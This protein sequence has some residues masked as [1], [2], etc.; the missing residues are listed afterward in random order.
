MNARERLAHRHFNDFMI[1]LTKGSIAPFTVKRLEAYAGDVDIDVSTLRPY[2]EDDNDFIRKVAVKI[3]GCFGDLSEL[4]KVIQREEDRMVILEA[5][6]QFA[7]RADDNVEDMLFLLDS[8]DVIVK[9]SV[10]NMFRRAGRA[11][12]LMTLLFDVDEALSQ[13]VKKWMEEQ[14][15]KEGK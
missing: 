2:L 13:R 12:C 14:D 5:C 3:W 8:E 7:K 11:D 9:Q 15:A 1:K 10:I 4:V 6:D